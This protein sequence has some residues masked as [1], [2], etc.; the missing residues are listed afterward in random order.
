VIALICPTGSRFVAV[1]EGAPRPF[2]G[3]STLAELHAYLGLALLCSPH[4]GELFRLGFPGIEVRALD[5]VV[6]GEP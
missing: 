2:V 1:L 4:R 6:V 5:G 3:A